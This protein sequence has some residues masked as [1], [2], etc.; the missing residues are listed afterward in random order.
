[1][2]GSGVHAAEPKSCS[3]PDDRAF[4]LAM[5]R[6]TTVE[7]RDAGKAKRESKTF[8]TTIGGSATRS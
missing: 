1:M 3:K 6:V 4:V 5:K 8:G 7:R 2:A